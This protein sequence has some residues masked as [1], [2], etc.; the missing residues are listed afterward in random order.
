MHYDVRVDV[1]SI[2]N[3]TCGQPID[4]SRVVYSAIK[5][6]RSERVAWF[7][8]LRLQ[9]VRCIVDKGLVVRLLMLYRSLTHELF[10]L[11]LLLLVIATSN[12]VHML[13]TWYFLE[14]AVLIYIK[15]LPWLVHN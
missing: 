2:Q 7:C 15:I 11:L 9:V 3:G 8:E 6:V 12:R 13:V 10:S 1:G 5:S 14:G 4:L